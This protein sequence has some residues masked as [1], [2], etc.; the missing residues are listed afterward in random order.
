MPRERTVLCLQ[1]SLP[2]MSSAAEG[3]F[4]CMSQAIVLL[5]G[6]LTQSY[7]FRTGELAEQA[8]SLLQTRNHHLQCPLV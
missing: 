2:S 7:L 3:I 1:G 8:G 5:A 6:M 4:Q